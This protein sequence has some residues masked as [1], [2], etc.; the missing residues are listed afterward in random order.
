MNDA[1]AERPCRFTT[2]GITVYRG[3]WSIAFVSNKLLLSTARGAGPCCGVLRPTLPL[4]AKEI[5]SFVLWLSTGETPRLDTCGNRWNICVAFNV[6]RFY[7]VFNGLRFGVQRQYKRESEPLCVFVEWSASATASSASS[8]PVSKK[9][10]RTSRWCISLS[11]SRL[12]LPVIH[13][14]SVQSIMIFLFSPL[15][16][17][18]LP[19]Q[20]ETQ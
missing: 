15:Q 9:L 5:C 6:Q 7:Y 11:S 8:S 18:N 1:R 19:I 14:H 2:H 20:T 13:S 3:S 16:H 17:V 12:S 10:W 4:R